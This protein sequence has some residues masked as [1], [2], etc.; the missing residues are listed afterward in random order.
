MVGLGEVL[1][2]GTGDFGAA[3]AALEQTMDSIS[4]PPHRAMVAGSLGMISALMGDFGPALAYGDELL[5]S[6]D[7]DAMGRL[8]LSLIWTVAAVSTGRMEDTQQR[9]DAA[10][11]LAIELRSLM[12]V[13]L[14]QVCLLYTSPSPRDATL[15]RMPSSA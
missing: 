11:D 7:I 3:S 12:P 9:L 4:D 6:P 14:D 5:D 8:N 1:A 15:S 13:A 2:F 10:R